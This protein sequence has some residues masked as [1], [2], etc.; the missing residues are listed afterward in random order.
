MLSIYET[1]QGRHLNGEPVA[2][3]PTMDDRL[4]SI[5]D[6]LIRLLN[7]RQGVLSH[8]PD[9]GLPDLNR[10]YQ[11]L[12]YS[13]GDMAM[14]VKSVIEKYEPRLHKVQVLPMPR[15]IQFAIV[16]ME[17]SGW[18]VGGNRVRFKTLFKSSGE[19]EVLSPTGS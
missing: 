12:P 5:H 6:H 13:E 19:A 7:A 16:R 1:L 11:D 9:Y 10:F 15:D 14:A 8:L 4:A 18:V 3:Y 2:E 17:I